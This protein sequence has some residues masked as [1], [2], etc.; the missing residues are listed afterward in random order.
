MWCAV[1]QCNTKHQYE[2]I[3]GV[4]TMKNWNI[5]KKMVPIY[6]LITLFTLVLFFAAFFIMKNVNANSEQAGAGTIRM[7]VFGFIVYIVIYFVSIFMV[8]RVIAKQVAYPA[9]DLMRAAEKLA[10]GDV[11]VMLERNTK[12]EMGVLTAAFVQMVAAMKEEA[13]VLAVIAQGDYTPNV[14][15]RSENDITNMAICKMLVNNN[16]LVSEIRRAATHVAGGAS[17]IARTSQSLAGGSTEQAA[18]VQ[19]LSA[20]IAEV[21]NQAQENTEVAD[22]AVA[23]VAEASRLM[24][25]SL[26]HMSEMAS[27]MGAIEVSSQEIAKVIKVIDDIAFQ[28]NILALNAAV[29]A[30]RAGEHGKGFAVVA[31]EVRNLASKSAAAAKETGLL[32]QSS[33]ENVKRG[34]QIANITG[35]SIG[36]V[37]ELSS[38]NAAAIG[39]MSEASGQQSAAINEINMAITQISHVVQ[40]N[41]ATAEESAASA[42]E[43]N[44]EAELLTRTVARFRLK[45]EEALPAGYLGA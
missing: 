18:T 22:A 30:A 7:F 11:D 5:R 23:D 41:S 25:K 20:S 21:Q 14:A 35:E 32:I 43:M 40:A 36:K 28:T 42:E 12:D 29:E 9:K 15:L 6:V 13:A 34:A 44:A 10:V 16:A 2:Q 24:G 19:E 38:A 17:Q 33:V 45:N 4:I 3:E 27:A 26:A 31:D 39:K 37:G 1:A 8:C